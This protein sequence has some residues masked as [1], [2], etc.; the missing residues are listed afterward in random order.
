VKI[1]SPKD[2]KPNPRIARKIFQNPTLQIIFFSN[3]N[4]GKTDGK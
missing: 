3:T 1:C 2:T 4:T